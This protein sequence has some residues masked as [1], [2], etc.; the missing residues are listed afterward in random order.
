MRRFAFLLVA[1]FAANPGFAKCGPEAAAGPTT[2]PLSALAIKTPVYMFER[3]GRFLKG[4][5]STGEWQKISDRGFDYTPTVVPSADGRWI[6]YSG[7]LND[8]RS[9][10][11]WLYDKQTGSDRMYHQHPAWG[12]AI[13]EFSPDGRS[14][15]L[16]A[17]YDKRWPSSEG[18]GLYVFDAATLRATFLGNPSKVATP[19]NQAFATAEW[20]R[21]GSELLLMMRGF[22]PGAE[23][24]REHFAY[25]IAEKRYESIK[26]EYNE[27]Q[28]GEKF[29]RNGAQIPIH[30]RDVVQSH[31]LYRNMPSPDRLW[32][33]A[34][35]TGY[36]LVVSNDKGDKK[37]VGA[38]RYD[39]C[40]GVTIGIN[41]WLDA[42]HM[43]YTIEGRAHVFDASTGRDAVLFPERPAAFAW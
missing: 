5:L 42:R 30:E 6:G 1:L 19:V 34:I 31:R 4:N 22:P 16:F 21:D 38:G 15:V 35:G 2:V 28:L 41:G 32:S 17:N 18:T 37:K 26:G 43:V 20:S 29:F 12:G 9:K 10:Q 39:N 27:R 36:E 23:P 3:S 25:R 13:P 7:E 8:R 24:S 33:A 40:S 14:I 11:Y